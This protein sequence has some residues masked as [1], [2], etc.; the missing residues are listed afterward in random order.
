MQGPALRRGLRGFTFILGVT[1]GGAAPAAAQADC[2]VTGQIGFVRDTLREYYLW[3]DRLPDLDPAAFSSPEA[4]L[5]AARFHPLDASFSYITSRAAQDAFYSESS[6][7]G[8]GFSSRQ[9]DS[10]EV[11]VSQV[12]PDSPAAEAG[13]A[14]G[15]RILEVDGRPIGEVIAGGGLTA[16]LGPAEVGLT[17]ELSFVDLRGRERREVL[18]KRVV[19][20][21]TVSQVEI[22]EVGRRRVGYL[23]FRNFVRP[24]YGA[25]DLAFQELSGAD[26]NELVLDLRY[27]GGGL[28]DV[29]EH[30]AGLVGGVSA[31]GHVLTELRHNEGNSFRNRYYRFP[32]PPSWALELSRVAIIT[33]GATASASEL[34]VMGLRPF[35]P[36]VLV[37]EATFGK[38]VG[39]YSFDFCESVLVPV[40]FRYVN[41]LGEG[42]FFDG[43]PA[44][45][46][47]PDDLEHPLGDESEASLGEALHWL[48]TGSCSDAGAEVGAAL[49]TRRPAGSG[50]EQLKNAH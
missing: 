4:Y 40:S 9:V 19:R 20:I 34:L 10:R 8:Y 2:S 26:V 46:P 14:R 18:V 38:P 7:V 44:D 5:Q 47:A 25:L 31:T 22:L 28:I 3:N 33:S 24:S 1:L 12:F 17:S 11:R 45:C 50:W 37:G 30:L 27:N 32:E 49:R 35:L 42:D 36:T 21:P 41:A 29:A 15:D 43:I 23:H 6:F 13:L 48:A 39:Q 16:A